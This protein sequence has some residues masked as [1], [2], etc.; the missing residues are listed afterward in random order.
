MIGVGLLYKP[1]GVGLSWQE[2]IYYKP[3]G[4]GLSWQENIY[5][6]SSLLSYVTQVQPTSHIM[7]HSLYS[8]SIDSWFKD[9]LPSS[10]LYGFPG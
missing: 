7:C 2:N 1:T 4:V 9:I 10:I 6:T 3:T 5:Y 8:H